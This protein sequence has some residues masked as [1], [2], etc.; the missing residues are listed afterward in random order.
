MYSVSSLHSKTRLDLENIKCKPEPGACTNVIWLIF[1]YSAHRLIL[2]SKRL[3]WRWGSFV[4]ELY[5]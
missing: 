4:V 1:G 2:N 5:D 3:L